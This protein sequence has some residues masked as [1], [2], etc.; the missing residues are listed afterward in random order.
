MKKRINKLEE[1]GEMIRKR[2]PTEVLYDLGKGEEKTELLVTYIDENTK[3]TNRIA[4][5]P[6]IKLYSENNKTLM[7]ISD[8]DNNA[9]R[10]FYKNLTPCNATFESPTHPPYELG[11][12]AVDLGEGKLLGISQYLR[13]E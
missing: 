7:D 10:Y 11:D 1:L 2:N 12:L 3:V 4:S 6:Q 9:D 13:A 5:S 8:S